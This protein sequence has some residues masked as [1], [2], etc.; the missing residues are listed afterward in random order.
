MGPVESADAQTSGEISPARMLAEPKANDF[1]LS[2]TPVCGYVLVGSV[3][4]SCSVPE[5][6]SLWRWFTVDDEG[7][8]VCHAAAGGV[9]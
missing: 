2:G 3:V 8:E 9:L 6:A 1:Q 5:G 7:V 4:Y